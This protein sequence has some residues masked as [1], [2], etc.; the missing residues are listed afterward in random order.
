M[1]R[2]RHRRPLGRPAAPQRHLQRVDDELAAY[3]IGD[4]P[5]DDPA[6]PGVEH[7]GQVA[8]ALRG[9]VLGDVHD[10]QPVRSLGVEPAA[11]QVVGWLG[12]RVASGAGPALSP[13]DILNAGLAH[14]ALDALTAA[15]VVLAQ[16]QFGMHPRRAI[17]PTA[18]P[19]DV[20][21]RVR[22]NGIGEIPVTH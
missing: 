2:V 21:D 1:V 11:H 16:S 7:D 9:G 10:P 20:H 13:I 3:V 8:L 5:T 18:H 22:E 17:G 12:R 15:A 19:V 14:E 6:A 4:R